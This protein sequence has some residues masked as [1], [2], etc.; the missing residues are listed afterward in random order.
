MRVWRPVNNGLTTLR[1]S[2][3]AVSPQTP[4]TLYLASEGGMF[5]TTDGA[6]SWKRIQ[7]PPIPKTAF[8]SALAVDPHNRENVYAGTTDYADHIVGRRPAVFKSSDGGA[9]WQTVEGVT[10]IRPVASWDGAKVALGV[11]CRGL[12]VSSDGGQTW[13]EPVPLPS[14]VLDASAVAAVRRGMPGDVGGL[15]DAVA[16]PIHST[17]VGLALYGWRHEPRVIN[18]TIISRRGDELKLLGQLDLYLSN[19]RIARHAYTQHTVRADG[20]VDQGVMEI[21]S[22]L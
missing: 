9:T 6:D 11:G 7:A 19:G 14:D 18:G 21:V 13:G 3:L 10:G 5:K 1:A 2:A 17:A 16:T 12:Y 22:R 20:P 4:A 8:V 15:S